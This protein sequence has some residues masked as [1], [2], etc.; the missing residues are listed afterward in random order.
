MW[1][2]QNGVGAAR[3]EAVA[4]E[5]IMSGAPRMVLVRNA[6]CMWNGFLC[7]VCG[8]GLVQ[9]AEWCW[10]GVRGIMLV[11]CIHNCAC[12]ARPMAQSGGTG[13][14]CTE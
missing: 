6:V 4:E 11:S 2:K 10:S 5:C 9:R 1:C 3:A 8:M 13:P 7:C 14:M 12:A